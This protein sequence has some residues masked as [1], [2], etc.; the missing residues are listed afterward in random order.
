MYFLS[1]HVKLFLRNQSNLQMVYFDLN[2]LM[3][4]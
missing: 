1:F 3:K 4:A 2:K